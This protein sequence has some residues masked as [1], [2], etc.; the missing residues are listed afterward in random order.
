LRPTS[1]TETSGEPVEQYNHI[2]LTEEEMDE[3]LRRARMEKHFLLARLEYS[4]KIAEPEPVLK[5]SS[6]E[7]IL[8]MTGTKTFRGHTF[9]FDNPKYKAIAVQLC[10][11]FAGD[12]RFTGDLSKGLALLGKPGNGKTSLM[13]FFAHN[14][15]HSYH[16]VSMLEI[17]TQY[18]ASGDDKEAGGEQAIK[19]Y[20][21]NTN[22]A[23][24]Q[25]GHSEYGLCLDE[26]GTEEIPVR[27][28][29]NS[30]N[31][32]AEIIQMRYM[33]RLCT[34][35]TTNKNQNEMMDMYGSRVYDR[36]KEMFNIFDFEGI[37]S[38]RL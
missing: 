19:K 29:A 10:Y 7:L 36:L 26:V 30:M 6:D 25:F 20:F 38:F 5:L 13:M 34:H 18:K 23:K 4:K 31:L 35:M 14:Q 22:R 33:N 17:A 8:V 24:D 16:V 9:N 11:Y 21:H 32:F 15:I 28:Y 1:S 2:D 27:H 3:A 37:D 12:Q